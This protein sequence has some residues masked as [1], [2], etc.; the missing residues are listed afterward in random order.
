MQ[1]EENH[2]LKKNQVF[3]LLYISKIEKIIERQTQ[4]IKKKQQ[5][6]TNFKNKV[7]NFLMP[8]RRK[9]QEILFVYFGDIFEAKLSSKIKILRSTSMVSCSRLVI[10]HMF[11]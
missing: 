1:R 11:Q 5:K 7:W 4:S 2:F 10:E 8:E 9:C 3:I 6:S